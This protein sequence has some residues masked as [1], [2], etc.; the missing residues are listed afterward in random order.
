[1][2]NTG[3]LDSLSEGEISFVT[4][5]YFY[6]LIRGTQNAADTVDDRV[7]VFDDPVSSLDNDVLYWRDWSSDVCSSDLQGK[8]IKQ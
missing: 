3:S 1:M 6:F 7:I 5:L 8:D 4:F 2:I